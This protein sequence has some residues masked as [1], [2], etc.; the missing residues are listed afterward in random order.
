MI[1]KDGKIYDI[2][3]WFASPGC[4]A[5]ATLLITVGEILRANNVAQ[6]VTMWFGIAGAIVAAIGT[7][8]G[9]FTRV[10]S[11]KYWESRPDSTPIDQNEKE[12]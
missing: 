6:S 9:E 3:K 4:P 12:D 1:F 7:C 10:S 2:L 11:K 8:L 5:I